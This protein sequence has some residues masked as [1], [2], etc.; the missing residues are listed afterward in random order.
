MISSPL[1]SSGVLIVVMSFSGSYI[2]GISEP[3]LRFS[4]NYSILSKPDNGEGIH[5]DPETIRHYFETVPQIH[6]EVTEKCNFNCSYCGYGENYEQPIIRPLHTERFM[7]WDLAKLFIDQY[8]DIWKNQKASRR[9]IVGFY[10]GE[11]LLNFAL[12]EKIV[13]YLTENSPRYITFIWTITTNGFLLKRHLEFLLQH[14]FNVDISIDGDSTADC[15][16]VFHDGSPTFSYVIKNI[17]YLYENYPEFFREHV[18]VQSVINHKARVT[19]VVAFFKERYGIIPKIMELSR[20]NLCRNNLIDSIFRSVKND[21]E[22]SYKEDKQLFDKYKIDSPFTSRLTGIIRTFSPN[23]Y[24]DY[25]D[26][27]RL[28]DKERTKD[29][30]ESATCLPFS[31]RIFL[32]VPGYIFPCE[33][34]DFAHPL[35]LIQDGKINL[36]LE[37]IS[38]MYTSL[39][40]RL[41][42]LCPT[43][44]HHNNCHHCFM[45]DGCFDD[46]TIKCT[47]YQKISPESIEERIEYL[48]SNSQYLSKLY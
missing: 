21:L 17:D 14:Q 10:G 47:D 48:R 40:M 42:K 44:L 6:F 8:I 22:C 16:R 45:Q 19:D 3:V 7:S 39:F 34:V 23:I 29:N 38:R 20:I 33:R 43:C 4:D 24:G 1:C 37:E 35:G 41:K 25:L 46:S 26:F 13:N 9:I 5:I 11:P 32:T 12:I 30:F 2:F 18:S 28:R 27:F 36:N 15:Y 31:T